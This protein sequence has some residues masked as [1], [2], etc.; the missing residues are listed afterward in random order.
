MHAIKPRQRKQLASPGLLANRKGLFRVI[1]VFAI[2]KALSEWPEEP[3]E[4]NLCYEGRQ[5]LKLKSKFINRSS[6]HFENAIF[7]SERHFFS[8]KRT[9]AHRYTWDRRVLA[10]SI[11]QS[12][13]PCLGGN[14]TLFDEF[15]LACL[16]KFT[17]DTNY[18]SNMY[19]WH[20]TRVSGI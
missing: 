12:I 5:F 10:P 7:R 14:E 13:Q 1:T 16:H 3:N 2:A 15:C 20:P 11:K 6:V 18:T 19:K 9:Q 8:I 4:K 17:R